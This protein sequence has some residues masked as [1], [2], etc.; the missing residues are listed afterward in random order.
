MDT[1]GW[2]DESYEVK[3]VLVRIDDVTLRIYFCCQLLL[4]GECYIVHI[5]RINSASEIEDYQREQ[6]MFYMIMMGE[7]PTE[8]LKGYP[9]LVAAFSALKLGSLN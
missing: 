1:S 7:S 4:S 6:R 5:G 2:I 3:T 9:S 8:H